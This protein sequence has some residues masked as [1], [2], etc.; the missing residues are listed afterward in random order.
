MGARR[1]SARSY[2]QIQTF[3]SHR[4]DLLL[5]NFNHVCETFELQNIKN[6]I[7][8][9]NLQVRFLL[10]Q[11]T[12][13]C[14]SSTPTV[15]QYLQLFRPCQEL[16]AWRMVLAYPTNTTKQTRLIHSARRRSIMQGQDTI[17]SWLLLPLTADLNSCTKPTLERAEQKQN[18]KV[19]VSEEYQQWNKD[20]SLA[21][22]DFK[23]AS[24]WLRT[25]VS[26]SVNY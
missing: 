5:R 17:V 9:P 11:I 15:S 10:H 19:A 22:P 16:W 13:L 26:E 1:A 20:G 3:N 8:K 6:W 7:F 18:T 14:K 21:V 2:V 25:Q 23:A 24:P 4:T 12:I